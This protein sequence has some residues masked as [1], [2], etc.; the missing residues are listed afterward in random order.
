MDTVRIATLQYFIRPVASFADFRAQVSGLIETAADYRCRLIVF[1]EYFSLQLLTLGDVTRSMTEQVRDLA[2]QSPEILAMIRELAIK[3]DIYVVAGTV[4]IEDS[5]SGHLHNVCHVI[6]PD[7]SVGAQPK[8]HM[9][10]FEREEWDIESVRE[11]NTFETDF[12][13]LGVAICYDVEFPEIVREHARNGANIIVVPS[14]TDDRQGFL[15]VR[16]CAQARAI[17]NQVFVVQS[18]TVGSLPSVPAVSL[19][20]GQASILTPSDFAFSRDGIA[21]EGIPNQ[22]AMVIADVNLSA[23]ADSRA[24][25]TVLPLVDAERYR[26]KPIVSTLRRLGP[27]GEHDFVVRSTR[28]TDFDAISELCRRVYP[29]SLPWTERQ[30]ASH[31]EVF[32]EG[33]FV[34]VHTKSQRVV[35]MAASLILRWDDYDPMSAWK[36]FTLSGMFTNHNPDEGRTLYAAEV[37][38]DPDHQG[39]GIG[40][41]LYDARRELV[42]RRRLL[43]IRAGARLRGYG[44]FAAEHT[45]EE[46]TARVCRGEISDQTL[47]FQLKRGFR[48]L[49]VVGNYLANDTESRGFAALIEWLN[50]E[51]ATPGDYALQPDRFR[52]R[53]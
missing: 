23:I 1:P 44:R 19:N 12:G 48:V 11:I 38:V 29:D 17:E 33:Q 15:R 52:A 40:R 43:R 14:C 32:P 45:P 50:P 3:N 27:A 9:T 13:R 4:L 16:Y 36:D 35:G 6:G 10:R 8:I 22:E 41:L 2:R 34:A 25:G 7:G 20:Y 24:M 5:E 21:A 47:T 37:M 51:I 18:S 53:R 28:P 30:L 46:Y 39:S 26:N 49:D 42:Q 31:L